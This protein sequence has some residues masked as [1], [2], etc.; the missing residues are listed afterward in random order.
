MQAPFFDLG[1]LHQLIRTEL[2]AA[3]HRVI[4]SGWF[5]IGPELAAWESAFAAYCKVKLCLGVGNGQDALYP[6]LCAYGIR[7]R[8]EFIAPS[9]TVIATWIA[10]RLKYLRW[11]R[12][13]S[14]L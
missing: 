14:V 7:P 6:L 13:L 4:D 12:L 3:Y 10:V 8:D 2:N 9:N 5:I 11:P 1:R